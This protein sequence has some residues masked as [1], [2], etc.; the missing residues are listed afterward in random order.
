MSINRK[1]SFKYLRMT[2][3][4]DHTSSDDSWLKLLFVSSLV[5]KVFVV[6]LEWKDIRLQKVDL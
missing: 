2:V 5:G 3:L 4:N 1:F 6:Y